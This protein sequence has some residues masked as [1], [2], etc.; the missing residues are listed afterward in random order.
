MKLLIT[1]DAMII[2]EMIKEIA[3]EVGLEVVGEA[4]NGQEAIDK[5]KEFSPDL[6]TLDLVMPNFDGLHALRG[7]REISSSAK[8]IVI[9]ALDQK[10]VLRNALSAGAT[11]FVVKPFKKDELIKTLR[12]HCGVSAGI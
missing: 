7:I 9:S 5:F 2:R 11:D 1:D 10:E 12:T 8:V 6:V 4:E 3:A